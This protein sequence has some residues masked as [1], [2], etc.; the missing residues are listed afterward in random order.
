M[1]E[2]DLLS[3]IRTTWL[4]NATQ[5][6]GRGLGMRA[7]LQ[8]ELER[9]FDLL[10]Q[11]LETGDP[12]WLDSLIQMWASSLTQTDLE[13]HTSELLPFFDILTATTFEACFESLEPTSAY[14]LYRVL[15]PFL[16]YAAEKANSLELE[17]RMTYAS[18]QLTQVRD[19]LE[20]LDR[21]KSDFIAVAAHELRTP[22]TLVEGYTSML[23]ERL[24][25][26]GDSESDRQMLIQ[27]IQGGADRL[28][29]IIEDMIDVSLLDN[30]LLSLNFQ[31]LWLNQ[32]FTMLRTEIELDLKERHQ[33][34]KVE[35]NPSF[36][37]MTYGDSERMLQVF[38]NVVKNAI[39]YTP[40]GGRIEISGRILP[41]FIDVTI[42]DT[43]I[44]IN[45]DDQ[46]L[47]FNK[48]TRLGNT[49]LHS[50]GKT[51]FKGG[52][53]G[54][55]LHIAK[56]IIEAHGGAIWADSNGYDEKKCPGSTFHILIP[57]RKEAPDD[58]TAK[59]FASLTQSQITHEDE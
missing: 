27:G 12:S 30:N 17:V 1:Q 29:T 10:S 31:P 37:E 33:V 47:I 34:F 53:P 16:I 6:L 5:K 43:G 26:G 24:P 4:Q 40:D 55:G 46:I 14:Q 20:R 15:L 23:A 44:G 38:R 7:D 18:D 48:F 49:A 39:K 42:S 32:I 52:G 51:K 54:L 56:G 25:V 21:S 58:K 36:S 50:S 13:S 59:L 57:M 41:G 9:F 35:E 3:S 22:L 28:R 45:P 19:S 2:F 11:T 8:F